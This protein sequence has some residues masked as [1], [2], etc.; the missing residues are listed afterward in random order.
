MSHEHMAQGA[1]AASVNGLNVMTNRCMWCWLTCLWKLC[2][3]I[4]GPH[5]TVCAVD[6]KGAVLWKGTVVM[7][8]PVSLG[9]HCG[10][11]IGLLTISLY[12]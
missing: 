4:P 2:Q 7:E 12:G 3:G 8:C 11:D 5:D 9:C 10:V 1:R 6:S